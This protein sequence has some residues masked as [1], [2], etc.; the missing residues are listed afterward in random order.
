MS[1]WFLAAI[2]CVRASA[3]VGEI[4]REAPP[5]SDS[6]GG[7]KGAGA[8]LSGSGPV[9]LNSGSKNDKQKGGSSGGGSKE[10][11]GTEKSDGGEGGNSNQGSGGKPMEKPG[12]ATQDNQGTGGKGS[13]KAVAKLLAK[14]PQ[15]KFA[16]A[17]EQI[18]PD[19]V[20]GNAA[21]RAGQFNGNQL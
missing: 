20:V 9:T 1:A 19:F 12:E 17:D 6:I 4:G 7:V 8:T 13:E 16:E 21:K 15:L 3:L 14:N 18:A 2:F 11:G 10:K 5:V